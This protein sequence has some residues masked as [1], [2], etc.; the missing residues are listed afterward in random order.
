[1]HEQDN[2]K[3]IRDAAGKDVL[4]AQEKGYDT[5]TKVADSKCIAAQKW[6][7][8]NNAVWKN[9]RNKWQTVFDRKKDITLENKVENKA[10]FS[11]LF[12]LKPDAEKA[13]SDAIIDKFVK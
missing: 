6:W 7:T 9:V 11:H 3:I 12:N 8:A 2:D 13:S 4:L 10:L 1:L 5:Y